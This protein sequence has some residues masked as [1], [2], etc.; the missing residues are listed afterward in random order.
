[1]KIKQKF[2]LSLL[3]VGMVVLF[4]A[5]NLLQSM[6]FGQAYIDLTADKRYSLTSQSVEFL[7]KNDTP[8]MIRMYQSKDLLKQNRI[9]GEY[10]EYVRK[11]LLEY[12]KYG[13]KKIDLSIVEVEPFANTQVEAE[14]SGIKPVDFNDGKGLL[15]LGASFI[16]ADGRSEVIDKF[17]PERINSVEDDITRL[18]SVLVK[19]NKTTLGIISPFIKVAESGN[20]LHQKDKH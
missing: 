3:I 1:M 18:L 9:L 19:K 8:I 15:Y 12:K 16:T 11:L 6:L 4:I 17:D 10:G 5:V 2:S 7:K 13:G 20:V 14:K